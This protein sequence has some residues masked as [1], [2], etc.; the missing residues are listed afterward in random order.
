MKTLLLSFL[1]NIISFI[2]L[3][4]A[5]GGGAKDKALL[6]DLKRIMLPQITKPLLAVTHN[7]P[8]RVKEWKYRSIG[9][10]CDSRA[11]E[12]VSLLTLTP[13]E[14]ASVFSSGWRRVVVLSHLTTEEQIAFLREQHKEARGMGIVN[15][16]IFLEKVIETLSNGGIS[17]EVFDA[18]FEQIREEETSPASFSRVLKDIPYEASDTWI[19]SFISKYMTNQDVAKAKQRAAGSPIYPLLLANPAPNAPEEKEAAYN[20]DIE[21]ILSVMSTLPNEHL[22]SMIK[23]I[24]GK[25]RKTTSDVLDTVIRKPEQLNLANS[26]KL[27]TIKNDMASELAEKRQIPI[28]KKRTTEDQLDEL[29]NLLSK[30]NEANPNPSEESA[31]QS[32]A[33]QNTIK[34]LLVQLESDEEKHKQ[35]TDF[36]LDF[37]QYRSQVKNNMQ[38]NSTY[39]V[40]LEYIGQELQ[41]TT[42][43][44][45]Q[46]VGDI[47]K[48]QYFVYLMELR[49]KDSQTELNDYKYLTDEMESDPAMRNRIADMVELFNRVE[50]MWEDR[51]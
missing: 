50:K 23:Y 6:N 36:L 9:V 37:N 11:E 39:F 14:A 43:D 28:K 22:L 40:F 33:E 41:P 29:I 51:Y 44:Q 16:E 38:E 13:Q 49:R 8:C 25:Y 2:H 19:L 32:T 24:A 1:L 27:T 17:Y 4:Q 45:A 31:E 48:A 18:L 12:E 20:K 42:R 21:Y 3:A 30:H 7:L 26:K 5:N 34:K 35:L 46:P 15:R 10:I 47:M